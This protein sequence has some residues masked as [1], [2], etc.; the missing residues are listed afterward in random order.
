M[1][2]LGGKKSAVVTEEALGLGRYGKV[3]T[4]LHSSRIGPENEPDDGREEEKLKESWTPRFR[5]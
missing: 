4:I 1:D 3:L 2:W 5:R